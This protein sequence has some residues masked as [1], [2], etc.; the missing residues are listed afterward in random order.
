MITLYEPLGLSKGHKLLEIGLGTGYS[1]IVAREIVGAE[2]LVVCVEID[3]AV[4]EDGKRFV[5]HSGFNDIVLILGDGARGYAEMAPY[6]R[7]CVTAAGAEV[8]PSLF[9][10]LTNAGKLI[11]PIVRGGIQNI[12]LFEKDGDIVREK[13][14]E[15]DILNIPFVPMQGE[16]GL[17]AD[18]DDSK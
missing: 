4:F 5:R 11:A 15:E 9:A 12:I 6:D 17:A 8:P 18:N 14:I 13:A 10:Q 2:G 16:Y 7:I 3:P 1:V